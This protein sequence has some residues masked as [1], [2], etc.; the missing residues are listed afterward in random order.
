MYEENFA[1]TPFNPMEL[2]G[3]ASG[4]Y[5]YIMYFKSKDSKQKDSENKGEV[6][7]VK[8]R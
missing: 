1:D 5:D 4:M 8:K 7:K 2:S 6:Q 3:I